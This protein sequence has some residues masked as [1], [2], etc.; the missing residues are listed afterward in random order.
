L[1]CAAVLQKPRIVRRSLL[2]YFVNFKQVV[3]YIRMQCLCKESEQVIIYEL[4][5]S[6]SAKVQILLAASKDDLK[7]LIR[8]AQISRVL[9]YA[10]FP[11]ALAG[12]V[13]RHQL[14]QL[15]RAALAA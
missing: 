8:R 4:S 13:C 12:L 1:F 7:K 15:H 2:G 14:S 11:R 9:N 3:Y 10:R 6:E 5:A